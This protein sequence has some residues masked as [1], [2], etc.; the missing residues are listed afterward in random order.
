[1]II[2][3]LSASLS[4]LGGGLSGLGEFLR[5]MISSLETFCSCSGDGVLLLDLGAYS[6]SSVSRF[7]STSGP[8]DE[9]P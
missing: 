9:R 8:A 1:M 7:L 4:R 3:S 5:I 6:K 2:S